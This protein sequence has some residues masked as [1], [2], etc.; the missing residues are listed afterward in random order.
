MFLHLLNRGRGSSSDTHIHAIQRVR[1]A[2]FVGPSRNPLVLSGIPFNLI[3]GFYRRKLWAGAPA[4]ITFR[5][6]FQPPGKC[7]GLMFTMAEARSRKLA[8][9]AG[10]R[11]DFRVCSTSQRLACNLSNLPNSFQEKSESNQHQRWQGKG[12]AKPK[13]SAKVRQ[14]KPMIHV[15][16]NHR[17][18]RQI[19]IGVPGKRQRGNQEDKIACRK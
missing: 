19:R 14:Q 13:P 6:F 8:T 3:V 12:G 10:F 11:V 2:G 4:A 9:S 15:R 16:I 1:C 17:R 18:I 5:G 7:R